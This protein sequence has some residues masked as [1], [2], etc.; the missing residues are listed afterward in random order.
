M[1]PWK[2][3]C[4]F[5]QVLRTKEAGKESVQK[6]QQRGGKLYSVGKQ[7]TKNGGVEAIYMSCMHATGNKRPK[8]SG[9]RAGKGKKGLRLS[10]QRWQAWW[11]GEGSAQGETCGENSYLIA[12]FHRGGHC[13]YFC[14][15]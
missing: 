4:Q 13:K 8:D 1:G 2:P 14:L 7:R 9:G 11:P 5:P 10:V 12:Q 15:L 3:T 6:W